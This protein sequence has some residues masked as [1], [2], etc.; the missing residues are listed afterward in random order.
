MNPT[1]KTAAKTAT[2]PSTTAAWA[3]ATALGAVGS[4]AASAHADVV[5]VNQTLTFSTTGD[6]WN[7]EGAGGTT[8]L[9][10][11][12]IGSNSGSF[13]NFPGFNGFRFAD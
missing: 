2:R 3:A 1:Q 7:L 13:P 8:A 12:F 6:T 5:F 9:A 11:V 4:L 10:S